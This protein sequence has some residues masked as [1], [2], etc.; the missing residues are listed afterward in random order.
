MK[1]SMMRSIFRVSIFLDKFDLL[2]PSNRAQLHGRE[3]F[4][5]FSPVPEQLTLPCMYP[6]ILASDPEPG[7]W[8][9]HPTLCG[10]QPLPIPDIAATPIPGLTIRKGPFRSGW[11]VVPMP[12]LSLARAGPPSVSESLPESTDRNVL[13]DPVGSEVVRSSTTSRAGQSV[14]RNGTES[15]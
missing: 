3:G 9:D 7:R 13:V 15:R 10:W 1:A 8:S 5:T 4:P 6:R 12:A 2:G 14:P 11:R